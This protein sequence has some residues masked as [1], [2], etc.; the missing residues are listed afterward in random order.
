MDTDARIFWNLNTTINI[1]WDQLRHTHHLELRPMQQK[2]PLQNSLGSASIGSNGDVATV[3]SFA[4]PSMLSRNDLVCCFRQQGHV[5]R[6]PCMSIFVRP[7]AGNLFPF[8]R[9]QRRFVNLFSPRSK[10]L[11]FWSKSEI[12]MR[13]YSLALACGDHTGLEARRP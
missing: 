13:A 8:S 2:Q 6:T 10:Y 9:P 7:L 11:D 4:C 5:R 12:W 3:Y 1:K